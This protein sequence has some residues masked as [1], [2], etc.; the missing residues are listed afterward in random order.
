VLS[1]ARRRLQIRP[2]IIFFESSVLHNGK[3]RDFNTKYLDC[4][5]AFGSLPEFQNGMVLSREVP[6]RTNL[7]VKI[8]TYDN[9]LAKATGRKLNFVQLPFNHPGFIVCCL[10]L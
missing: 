4:F 5:E 8:E 2:K 3:H 7:N 10:G 9:L 6:I 1:V